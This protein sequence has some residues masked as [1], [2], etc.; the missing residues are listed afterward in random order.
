MGHPSRTSDNASDIRQPGLYTGD[1]NGSVSSKMGHRQPS[2]E[3]I[4]LNYE[5][6]SDEVLVELYKDKRDQIALT[7]IIKRYR[8][9]ILGFAMKMTKNHS[10]AEDVVQEISLTLV[11]K[12]DSFKGNSKFSTW[13]YKVT[14]NTCYMVLNRTKKKTKH[15]VNA[16]YLDDAPAPDSQSPG[17]WSDTPSRIN[18][19]K[20]SAE[21][22]EQAVNELSEHNREIIRLKD[23]EGY[24]NAQVGEI[25]GIS[26]SAVKSRLLRSRLTLRKK[27]GPNFVENY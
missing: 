1:F 9:T 22:I 5:T 12:L 6:V 8:D 15:E 7:N 25:M 14:I 20:E 13:L 26:I 27:L 3:L 18:Q 17:K 11:K 24:S 21:I 23:M 16:E 2:G 19:Y 10:D 4:P